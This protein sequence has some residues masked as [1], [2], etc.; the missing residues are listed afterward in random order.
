MKHLSYF[1]VFPGEQKRVSTGIE[2]TVYDVRS[3]LG[4]H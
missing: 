1:H 2:R 4:I 3:Y